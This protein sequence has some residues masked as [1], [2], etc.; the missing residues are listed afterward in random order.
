[1]SKL[2]LNGLL[3]SR[4][5]GRHGEVVV[6]SSRNGR[7]FTARPPS[8]S[9]APPS[10]PQRQIQNRFKLA[11]G[12]ASSVLRDPLKR[13]AYEQAAESRGSSVFIQAMGDYLRP[14]E[15]TL[16][17]VSKYRGRVGDRITVLATD[18]TS[19]ASVTVK[20]TSATDAVLEEGA[21]AFVDS[22]WTYTGATLLPVGQPVTITATAEDRPGNRT[23]LQST[24]TPS[25]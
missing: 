8:P 3:V 15:I 4:M 14:P 18:D 19:V 1:M 22:Q 6:R 13:A 20:V 7:T 9:S 16:L 25:A 17:D 23:S 11:N 2:V 24:L 21:A 12:Y 5:S 10:A